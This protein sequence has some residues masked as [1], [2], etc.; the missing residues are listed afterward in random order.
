MTKF[1]GYG[2]QGPLS[3]RSKPLRKHVF[4]LPKRT[5]FMTKLG[6]HLVMQSS[7]L[8]GVWHTLSANTGE[9]LVSVQAGPFRC[10][11]PS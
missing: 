8:V 5:H 1:L 11:P 10:G 3:K 7:D 6:L 2:S 4:A 9:L